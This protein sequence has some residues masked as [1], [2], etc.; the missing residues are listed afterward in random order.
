LISEIFFL[1]LWIL[2]P[3]PFFLSVSFNSIEDSIQVRQQASTTGEDQS[4]R[5]EN[6][7]FR[8]PLVYRP[9]HWSQVGTLVIGQ[10]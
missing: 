10:R 3:F 6:R 9:R 1:N 8:N 7:L 2:F 4:A 5:A